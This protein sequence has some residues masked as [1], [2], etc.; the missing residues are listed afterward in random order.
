MSSFFERLATRKPG[1][2][3]IKLL[4]L[5]YSTSDGVVTLAVP[6]TTFDDV[7]ALQTTH[8]QLLH[9]SPTFIVSFIANLLK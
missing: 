2:Y 3:F 7:N 1:I 5:Q 6:R 4:L 8:F 9:I